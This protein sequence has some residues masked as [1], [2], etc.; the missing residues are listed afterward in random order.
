[1]TAPILR[2]R[3]PSEIVDAAFQ[4]LRAHYGHLVTCSAIAYAPLLLLRLLVVGDPM[5]FLGGDPAAIPAGALSSTG[6]ALLGGWLTFS[7]M[8]AVLLVCASQA[9]LGEDVDVAAAVRSALPRLPQVLAA[10]M[11]RFVLMAF[12]FVLMIFPV[13]YVVALLFAVTPVIV[14]E[15]GS[16]VGSLRRSASLSKGRKWHILNTL[17]LVAIIYYV[18]V[19]GVSLLA[20]LFGNFVLSTV[21]SAVVTV[22]VYPVVAIAE[23]LLYYDARIQ[24]EGL[25]IEL[26]TGALAA[27][28]GSARATP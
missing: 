17:G 9:Y 7:L 5:R 26:M 27:S 12:A 23:A 14:L 6:V 28:A 21:A 16:V 3:S 1:M 18:L 20:S 15:R 25:D 11:L 19:L 24:S 13:L 10:A 2:P 8:S 22:L 4:L